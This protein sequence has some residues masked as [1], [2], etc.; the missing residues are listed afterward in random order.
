LVLGSGIA[1]LRIALRLAEHGSVCLA[2]KR[3]LADSNTN[4]AQGG[5][6]AVLGPD[7]SFAAHAADTLAAGGG[8]CHRPIV[9]R[10]VAAGP[11]MI[12]DLVQIGVNFDRA[13]SGPN[14]ELGREGGHSH[15]RIVHAGD[16]TGQALE[17]GL[18]VRVRAD[19]R[20]RC[21]EN[22]MGIDLLHDG[23][24]VQGAVLLD[25]VGELFE[26]PARVTVLAT[27]GSGKVYRYT[28]NPDVATG[29]GL[30]MAYRAG[31]TLANLEFFQ[32]HP[33]CLFHPAAKNFLLSEALRGEGAL[34]FNLAGERFL[35]RHDPRAE[36]APRD[37]VARAI[38]AEMKQ[39]GDEHVLLDARPIGRERI[40]ER[41]PNILSRCLEFG[42]DLRQQ[43][44]PIVPAAH[45]QCGGVLVDGDGASDLPG[46]YVIGEAACTGLHGANRL[47]SNSLLEALYFAH[48]AA[49]RI[50]RELPDLPPPRDGLALRFGT[51]P[52]PKV[53][54]RHDW[55]LAR[56][57]MWDYV[58]IVR[59]A[60]RLAIAGAR[61]R[62]LAQDCQHWLDRHLPTPGLFELRNLLCLGE[63]MVRAADFRCETRG[64]HVRT[65]VAAAMPEF[66]GDTLL[67]VERAP[68]LAPIA[69][70]SR[71]GAAT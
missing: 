27:G 45:Y 66:E 2:T 4:L 22:C 35:Q 29:D 54:L 43:A 31:A 46:L 57:T 41:F 5:I 61:L 55:E 48:A 71:G 3:G 63:L 38:D 37:V 68:W 67:R 32:F 39:R 47:A 58:G 1:G 24:R 36:L 19:R 18:A 9:E 60:E 10:V 11:R 16:F 30:A 20:I 6:S 40:A 15:R 8:L 65:E 28:S 51:A 12:E 50:G 56:R 62:Q 52:L 14:Y 7:D 25:P 33:T 42:M 44:I 34:V 17:Q 21:V 49:T 23:E 64:L 53:A 69:V 59:D 13:A 70:A 26:Q